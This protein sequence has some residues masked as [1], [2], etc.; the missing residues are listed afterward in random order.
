VQFGVL[1]GPPTVAA[2]PNP[3]SSIETGPQQHVTLPTERRQTEERQHNTYPTASK[4]R[5]NM[6][7]TVSREGCELRAL[8]CA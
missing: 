1:I 4:I 6:R 7:F 8:R 2:F 5:L 3:A